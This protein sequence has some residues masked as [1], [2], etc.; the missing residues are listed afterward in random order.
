MTLIDDLRTAWSRAADDELSL[1]AAGVAFYAFLGLVPMLAAL[2]LVYGLVADPA[3]AVVHAARLTRLLPPDAGRI[4]NE[5]MGE[6]AAGGGGRTLLGLLVALATTFY[7]ASKGGRALLIALNLV[8]RVEE[9]RGTIGQ[10][11]A[12]LAIT[13]AAIAGG[14]LA[15]AAISLLGFAEALLPGLSGLTYVLLRGGLWLLLGALAVTGLGLLYARAPNHPP[16]RLRD[17]VPGALLATVLLLAASLC[18]A[19]YVARFGNYNATYG[20]L[21]AV[22]VLQLWLYLSAFAV[23]L[24]AEYQAVR[25]GVGTAP[26][27]GE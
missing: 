21:G 19:L 20:A 2:V 24:G 1:V 18:F 11:L 12:A 6:V 8:E 25:R 5:Q 23:L 14:I 13:A 26:A 4:I 22:V 9:D 7:S 27:P 16:A 10:T 17:T 3:D 15:L